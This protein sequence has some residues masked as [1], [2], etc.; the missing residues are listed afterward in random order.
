MG[1]GCE[2]LGS[3]LDALLKADIAHAESEL[4]GL[5]HR[6]RLDGSK[7]SACGTFLSVKHHDD[8]WFK[9]LHVF[10]P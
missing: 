6:C 4:S 5:A 3:L 8:G 2:C 1:I 7:G 9:R 10:D